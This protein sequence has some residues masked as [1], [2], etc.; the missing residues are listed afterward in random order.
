MTCMSVNVTDGHWS[1]PLL[2]F[3]HSCVLTAEPRLGQHDAFGHMGRSASGGVRQSHLSSHRLLMPDQVFLMPDSNEE[4][5]LVGKLSGQNL[6][7]PSASNHSKAV[8]AHFF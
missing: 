4:H 1:N 8:L 2:T 5:C 7:S 6:A 3:S